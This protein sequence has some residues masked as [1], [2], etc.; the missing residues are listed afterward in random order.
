[1]KPV[2]K[3]I[4]L[5]NGSEWRAWLA[6]NHTDTAGIWLIYFKKHTGK[7]RVAYDEAVEE[8]LCFGWIDS[9]VKR[10][11]DERYM[12][13]FTPRNLK[14]NWSMPNKKRVQK[15][16]SERKMTEAGMRL[17]TFAKENGLWDKV[18]TPAP[19]FEFSD[20]ILHLLESDKM[21]FDFYLTLAPSQQKQYKHWVMSAKKE[22]TRLKRSNEMLDMLK[23][24]QKLGMK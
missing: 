3:Q 7:P 10:I 8:A 13:Q 23:R 4:Y 17:V 12:Q 15:L 1:M 14:S 18:E 9:T 21:A 19:N 6:E 2:F 11:D 20:K 22:E 5:R 16:I 24:K